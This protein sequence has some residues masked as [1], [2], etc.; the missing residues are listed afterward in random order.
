MTSPH[1][2]VAYRVSEQK[3]LWA[4]ASTG[5]GVTWEG[6]PVVPVIRGR[7]R[8]PSLADLLDTAYAAGA[9]RIMLTGKLPV[10]GPGVPHWLMAETPGWRHGA[11]W[12]EAPPTGRYYHQATQPVGDPRA[13]PLEVATAAAW[14]GSARLGFHQARAAW[15]L[16]AGALGRAEPKLSALMKSPAATGQNLWALSMPGN[17]DPAPVEA[18]IAE[19]IHRT[20]GQ[21][22]IEHLVAGPSF[23]DHPDCLPLIDPAQG[24]EGIEAFAY[25]DGRFMYAGLCNELAVGPGRRLRGIEAHYLFEESPYAPARYHIRF[26]VPHGWNHLGI[27]GVQVPGSASGWYWPN[28]PG[29]TAQT[30]VDAA[31]LRVGVAHGWV[32]DTFVEAVQFTAEKPALR[33]ERRAVAARPLDTFAE[34]LA[35]ARAAV[36]IAEVDA[37]V[38]AAARTALRA[39]LLET[40]GAFASRGRRS[41]VTVS[42]TFEVPEAYQHSIRV[43]GN[44]IT[45]QAP[46]PATERQ[47][48]FYHPELPA[49]VWGRARARVLAG[50]KAAPAGALHVDPHQLIG[51]NGDALYTTTV[52]TWALPTAHGGADDGRV[53]KLRLKGVLPG[54]LPVPVTRAAREALMHR[55][56]AAG[57]APAWQAGDEIGDEIGDGVSG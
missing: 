9:Q 19:E 1:R 31:E 10:S 26:T 28:R 30:W 22:H 21:H 15:E 16:V 40:I 29:A 4:D 48:Q 50:T 56:E 55:A 36:E 7:R 34:R 8:R 39:I 46:S 43:W 41:T 32:P 23:S 33:G 3:I 12:L 11:H 18:E 49:Q 27:W 2:P 5:Y 47:R 24:S 57:P 44:R 20:S 52:P 45:Y 35:N 13:R 17:L 53:G 6:R 54:P 25:I 14:F 38:K 37:A 42:S 51:I